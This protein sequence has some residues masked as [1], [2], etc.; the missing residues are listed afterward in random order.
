MK[1]NSRLP[2][3]NQ[4][5]VFITNYCCRFLQ[6]FRLKSIQPFCMA[7]SECVDTVKLKHSWALQ[8]RSLCWWA[9]GVFAGVK[10]ARSKQC[11]CQP[12]GMRGW[13]GRAVRGL[14]PAGGLRAAPLV[15]GCGGERACGYG[16]SKPA[17]LSLCLWVCVH[18][19]QQRMA[20]GCQKHIG[21]V[22]RASSVVTGE[23]YTFGL[24]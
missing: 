23:I 15:G 21:E 5:Q 11:F 18:A 20:S 4:H 6:L 12:S 3:Q 16:P 19:H 1:R 2:L 14:L 8:C 9:A 22:V 10:V 24:G 7:M 17:G 13:A